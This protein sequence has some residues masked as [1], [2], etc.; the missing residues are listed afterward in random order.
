M[1]PPQSPKPDEPDTPSSGN[2]TPFDTWMG[3][4][5]LTPF[6]VWKA[7]QQT[8]PPDQP[9]NAQQTLKENLPDVLATTGGVL[10][11][12]A[13]PETAPLWLAAGMSGA[14]QTVGRYLGEAGKASKLI[15]D[16]PA[17]NYG[18]E[19]GTGAAGEGLVRGMGNIFKRTPMTPEGSEVRDVLGNTAMIPQITGTPESPGRWNTALN[20]A[21]EGFL[22]KQGQAQRAAEQS[23][24]IRKGIGVTAKTVSPQGVL[25]PAEEGGEA[26]RQRLASQFDAAQKQGSQL[27]TDYMNVFGKTQANVRDEAGNIVMKNGKAV[28]T[29]PTLLQLHNQQTNLLQQ[30]R[31]LAAQNDYKGQADTFGKAMQIREQMQQMLEDNGQAGAYDAYRQLSSQ[32]H[33]IMSKFDNPTVAALRATPKEQLLDN[34]LKGKLQLFQPTGSRL[35][36]NQDQAVNLIHSALG[37]DSFHQLGADAIYRL[38]DNAVPDASKAAGANWTVHGNDFVNALSKLSPDVQEALWGKTVTDNLNK[39]GRVAA[40]TQRAP[41]GAGGLWIVMRQASAGLAAA[42]AAAEIGGAA[43]GNDTAENAGAAALTGAGVILGLPWLFDKVLRSDEATRLLVRTVKA[44]TQGMKDAAFH[45]LMGVMGR[46]AVFG[47]AQGAE[48]VFEEPNAPPPLRTGQT[49]TIPIPTP[50]GMSAYIPPP[51]A[52]K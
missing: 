41:R 3:K 13:A 46:S 39:L 50:G 27:Y 45:A 38:M 18:M 40:V 8:T 30:S 44:P 33:D 15:P 32:Y 47:G 24:I 49:A 35:T 17:W 6:D 20:I 48:S 1:P 10:G 36:I 43:F 16:V 14:G 51:P 52:R 9:I 34:I 29:G 19:F 25:N 4:Q 22:G 11:S 31:D 37:D 28:K 42:G 12:M 2:L 7:G 21:K 5:N 26:V 23:D